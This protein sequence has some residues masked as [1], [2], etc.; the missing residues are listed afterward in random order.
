MKDGFFYDK[1]EVNDPF[2]NRIQRIVTSF[3]FASLGFIV[4]NIFFQLMEAGLCHA[5]GYK[6]ELWFTHVTASPH[7]HKYWGTM[8][9]LFIYATPSLI[10]GIISVLI[11]RVSA[12][13]KNI[14]SL[15]RLFGVWLAY[16]MVVVFLQ[17]FISPIMGFLIPETYYY[18]TFAVILMWLGMPKVIVASMILPGVIMAMAWG[19]VYAH[20]ILRFSFSSR[21]IMSLNGKRYVWRQLY[22]YPF[23]LFMIFI[24]VLVYPNGFLFYVSFVVPF[25]FIGLGNLL[26]FH[27]DPMT[28]VACSKNDVVK[29]IPLIGILLLVLLTVTIRIYLV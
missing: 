3:V 17:H 16:G 1:L 14:I 27:N 5:F 12:S 6:V 18:G 24:L 28:T 26:R 19:Y 21:L 25:V 23:L 15:A 4:A 29:T 20:E 13:N 8:R 22:L 11:M 10:L 2:Q 7:E 9:V